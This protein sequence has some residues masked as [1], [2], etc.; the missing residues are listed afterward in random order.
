[1]YLCCDVEFEGREKY[2]THFDLEHDC[3]FALAPRIKCGFVG[4]CWTFSNTTLL[5]KHVLNHK[6][7]FDHVRYLKKLQENGND[8]YAPMPTDSSDHFGIIVS[9]HYDKV[10]RR[11]SFLYAKPS[12]TKELVGGSIQISEDVVYSEA[13]IFCDSVT[14]DELQQI[15]KASHIRCYPFVGFET[16]EK[17]MARFE[18]LGTLIP[19]EDYNVGPIGAFSVACVFELEPMLQYFFQQPG[20]LETVKNFMT[21]CENKRGELYQSFLQGKLWECKKALFPGKLVIPLTLYCGDFTIMDTELKMGAFYLNMPALPF[22]MQPLLDFVFIAGFHFSADRKEKYIGVEPVVGPIMERLQKL[23]DEGLTLDLGDSKTKV[24]FCLTHVQ[25]DNLLLDD[26]LQFPTTNACRFCTADEHQR[27]TMVRDEENLLRTEVTEAKVYCELN[28]YGVHYKSTDNWY[29]EIVKDFLEGVCKV[30]LVHILPDLIF[31]HKIIT[32]E[33]LN[34]RLLTFNYASQDRRHMPLAFSAV[35]LK[36]G[37]IRMDSDQIQ[38][39]VRNFPLIMAD[40]ML[41]DLNNEYKEQLLSWKLFTLMREI[42]YTLL[43]KTSAPRAEG[44]LRELVD[45]HHSLFK[46]F[47]PR[48]GTVPLAFHNATHYWR[49]IQQL[50][51]LA[52]QEARPKVSSRHCFG[53][54]TKEEVFD[55]VIWK[56]QMILN[57][58]LLVKNFTVQDDFKAPKLQNDVQP[59]ILRA[60]SYLGPV[61]GLKSVIRVKCFGEVFKVGAVVVIDIDG[62]VHPRFAQIEHILMSAERSDFTLLCAILRTDCYDNRLG[63]FCVS[64]TKPKQRQVVAKNGF[65]WRRCFNAHKILND[66]FVT[67]HANLHL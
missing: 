8:F 54:T 49:I 65:M 63:A 66:V 52:V 44:Q 61:D 34:Q 37:K 4:C 46:K 12:M 13:E 1:M 27:K 28:G 41:E 67:L 55:S 39:F 32:V 48:N 56:H 11:L 15:A 10:L 38:C 53:C 29:L 25:A 17:R 35:D 14:R 40:L 31:V 20:M 19:F 51:P 3:E 47:A 6:D 18:K 5:K 36:N 45:A 42:L 23:Q 57:D 59:D 2:L 26:L 62:G 64:E 33:T 60:F 24:Y 50:G 9:K 58:K 30:D 43:A 16:E 7:L 22:E 21:D